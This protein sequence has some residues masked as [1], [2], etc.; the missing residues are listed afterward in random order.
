MLEENNNQK[1]SNIYYR[2]EYISKVYNMSLDTFENFLKKSKLFI[3]NQNH[4]NHIEI[5][6]SSL[7]KILFQGQLEPNKYIL[8]SLYKYFI[9]LDKKVEENE[10]D[11]D[12]DEKVG[13]SDKDLEAKNRNENIFDSESIILN[14]KKDITLSK[15][16][17]S[18]NEYFNIILCNNLKINLFCLQ[19][20]YGM[21]FCCGLLKVF[22]FYDILTEFEDKSLICLN[23]LNKIFC[24]ALMGL[25]MV[26]GY[27]GY[28]NVKRKKYNDI[29]CSNLTLI[30]IISPL[31]GFAFS[32]LSSSDN[33]AKMV[34]TITNI[35]SSIASFLCVIIWQEFEKNNYL[36]IK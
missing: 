13:V 26:T 10:N 32:R 33:L 15:M 23:N 20:F 1:Q 9:A 19:F 4:L 30:C 25:L 3:A 36:E 18:E 11:T 21:I 2:K 34:N 6:Y 5:K 16:K 7:K 8:F 28:T 27:Y 31:I 12:L 29:F 22:Y 24:F 35:C 14:N 17:N